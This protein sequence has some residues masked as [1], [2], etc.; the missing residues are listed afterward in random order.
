MPHDRIEIGT[1]RTVNPA[2]RELRI[3][4]APARAKH[5]NQLEWIHVAPEGGEPMRCKV[6]ECREAAPGFIVSLAAGVSRESVADMRNARVYADA[7]TLSDQ[8]DALAPEDLEGMTVYDA[9][10]LKLGAVTYS[11]EAAGNLIIDVDTDDG[12]F[13]MPVVPESVERIDVEARTITVRDL[14][15][16][17]VDHAD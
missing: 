5:L 3:A 12:G 17:R 14:E 16:F 11:Q 1:V 15:R 7:G 4:A 6:V 8:S 10:G 2:K 9:E 13:T